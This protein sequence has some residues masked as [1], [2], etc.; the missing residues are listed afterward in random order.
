M[1]KYILILFILFF[2]INS[3]AYEYRVKPGDTLYKLLI[4]E[5][6]PIEISE[7]NKK[8]KKLVPR[9][10]LKSGSKVFFNEDETIFKIDLSKEI[11]VSKSDEKVN[12]TLDT[13]PVIRVNSVVSGTI[14]SS[15]L[16]AMIE[17]GEREELAYELA[18]ILEWEIDF[19]KDIRKGDKFNILVEKKF[20]KD[21]FVGYGRILAIDFINRGRLV[22]GLYYENKKTR[23][24]FTPDGKS[25]KKGF[26]K[27]PLKFSRI[28]SSYTSRRLHPVLKKYRPHYG[29][30]YAAPTGT[31]VHA[32]ADGR[33]IKRKYDR[34]GGYFVKIRHTN[35]YETLYM[36]FSRFRSGQH[37]GSYVKQG[38]VIGYVGSTGY[39]TGPHVDY[40]I[41]KHGKYLNPLRF[42]SPSKKL[43]KKVMP[44][45]IAKTE[46]Y[47]DFLDQTT[48]RYVFNSLIQN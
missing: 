42:R 26:L 29:V 33:I 2:S 28:S 45:F 40:R 15:L 22:R 36:H 47:K 25:L 11:K 38:D 1:F 21:K 10:T 16:R 8:I 17:A 35:G 13:F 43:P 18:N 7:I 44:D 37:V 20:C 23:G 6:T 14:E 34:G 19:F 24:F 30:D 27:A 48:Q 9:F 39:A 4:K 41:K 32:T 3:Y 12:V 31:P 46:A 5:Y